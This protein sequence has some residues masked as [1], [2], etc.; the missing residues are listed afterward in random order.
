[1]YGLLFVD[2]EEGVRRSVMRALRREKYQVYA[3]ESGQ[4]AISL[5][6]EKLDEIIVVVSDYKMPG[7]D[8]LEL[9]EYMGGVNPEIARILL[10][11]YATMEAA[12]HATNEGLD[13]FLTKP[14]D[15][16]EL[17]AKIHEILLKKRLRQFV[18]EPVYRE[19]QRSPFPL[20]PKAQEATISIADMTARR[21]SS[22]CEKG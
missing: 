20:A 16:V 15:N 14:F 2:D 3:A 21:M 10:T 5:L 8:G 7:M 11:G 18:S 6:R 13:G 22:S 9:L 12:I 1:M 4:V 17:R 19:L